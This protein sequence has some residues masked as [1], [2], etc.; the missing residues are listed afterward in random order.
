MSAT[1]GGEG[2]GVLAAV[3]HL[4]TTLIASAKTRLELIANEI[5]EEKMR[6]LR[7]LF[8]AHGL[9]F[10]LGLSAV[11]AVGWLCVRFWEER[12]LVLG[13]GFFFFLT[14]AFV[15]YR[16]VRAFAERPQRVFD[17]SIAELQEDIR[18]LK[19]ALENERQQTP[20]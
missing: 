17:A 19:A 16:F 3:V 1:P 15:F 9:L 20:K 12:L 11:M 2:G 10:C 6:A 18:Q 4:V 13:L 14:L 8:A 5:E 7:L